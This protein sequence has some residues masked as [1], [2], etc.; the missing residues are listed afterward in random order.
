LKD[1]TWLL[2]DTESKI[3]HT[4]TVQH[5]PTG[6]FYG[7]KQMGVKGLVFYILMSVREPIF[8]DFEIRI[9]PQKFAVDCQ[10]LKPMDARS[11][12]CSAACNNFIPTAYVRNMMT[13]GY[14]AG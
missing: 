9:T 12:G 13:W 14:L 4:Y 11:A 10:Q 7:I 6:Q 5:G 1:S 8:Q 2:R 3:N